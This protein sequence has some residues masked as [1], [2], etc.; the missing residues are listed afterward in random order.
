MKGAGGQKR[1][2]LGAFEIGARFDW[3]DL[4]DDRDGGAQVSGTAI[5]NW[6][7]TRQ[8]RFTATHVHSRVTAGPDRGDRIDATLLWA[9]FIY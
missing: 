2:G 6:Y 9:A 3:L 4:S 8:L 1:I 7:P 5:A